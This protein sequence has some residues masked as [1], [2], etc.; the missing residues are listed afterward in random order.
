MQVEPSGG[1][2]GSSV[3]AA[4][5]LP[6]VPQT[7]AYSSSKPNGLPPLRPTRS[8]LRTPYYLVGATRQNGT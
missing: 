5:T 2:G 8:S 6:R 7:V 4:A 3:A 1:D